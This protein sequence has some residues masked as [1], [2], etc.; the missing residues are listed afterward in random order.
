MEIKKEQNEEI[1]LA[2]AKAALA[3]V[4]DLI[5]EAQDILES[6]LLSDEREALLK[7]H[8]KL[9]KAKQKA[10]TELTVGDI[11]FFKAMQSEGH[12]ST[13][14]ISAKGARN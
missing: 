1:R 7:V 3:E 10:Y 4:L 9:K 14:S 2:K 12:S 5:I 13:F 6:G 11:A 8:H